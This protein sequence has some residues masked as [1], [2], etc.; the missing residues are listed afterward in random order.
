MAGVSDS[1]LD[2]VDHEV[3]RI[4]DEC[5]QEAERLLVENRRRLDN[6]AERLLIQETLDEPDIY[7]AAGIERVHQ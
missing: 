5:Y 6:I 7:A 3:R 1:L 2:A 4:I